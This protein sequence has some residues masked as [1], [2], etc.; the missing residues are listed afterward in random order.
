MHELLTT[1][2]MARADKAAIASG[3]SGITLMEAAGRAVAQAIRQG[4]SP[5]SVLVLAGPGNNGGDGFVTARLLAESGW[6]VRVA[7]LGDREAL[8]DDAASAAAQWD[9]PVVTLGEA[10]PEQADLIVDALFGA[11][12]SRPL[13][14]E[15][16]DLVGHVN[17]S[18]LPIVS[19]D[20][21]SGIDGN[22]GKVSGAA[23]EATQTV[24][25]FRRKPGHLLMPGRDHCGLVTLTDIGIPAAVLGDIAPATFVNGPDLWEASFPWPVTDTHKY[26]RGHAIMMSGGAYTS[27]AARLAA[28]GAARAG[29]GAVTMLAPAE[30]MTVNAQHL[31][32]IMLTE[33]ADGERISAFIAERKVKAGLIGP[34]AGRGSDTRDKVAALLF[35]DAQAVLDADALT[36]F[37]DEPDILFKALRHGDVLTP[38]PGEFARLYGDL[39]DTAPGKVDAVREAAGKAGSVVLLKGADTVIAAPDG[40]AAINANASPFL[41]TAGSGDV[42]AGIITGLMA[43]GM[44]GFE[45]ACAGVWLHAEAAQ[46]L[47][48]GLIASDLH[49]AL[50]LVLSSLYDGMS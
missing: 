18:G 5:R 39:L 7:L 2:Q 32:E 8:S 26:K 38:H 22:T 40:R 29:A 36:S 49:R 4:W 50:P 13:E 34:G 10:A 9:G 16:A 12:L 28:M 41:A 14:G 24:T 45:A 20:I 17:D 21:P 27:G 35:S 42:L 47:G 15:V 25:F 31:D 48:P 44:P 6:S 37:E 33:A 3:T 1:D 11:G 23:I 43:Q 30:A 19:I 46:H